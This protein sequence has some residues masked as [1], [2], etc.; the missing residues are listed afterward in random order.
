[1]AINEWDL[2]EKEA[3]FVSD[4]T[5]NML[6]AVSVMELLHLCSLSFGVPLLYQKSLSF[7]SVE[8]HEETFA[9]PVTKAS[10]T[11]ETYISPNTYRIT[12]LSTHILCLIRLL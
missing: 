4:K 1:M 11:N 2:T 5:A 7:L 9:H 3:A 8:E 10:R 6:Q 12:I